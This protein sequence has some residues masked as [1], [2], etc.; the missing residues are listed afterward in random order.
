MMLLLNI[1]LKYVLDLI[2]MSS[3]KQ[4]Q[5]QQYNS[6]VANLGLFFTLDNSD[7]DLLASSLKICCIQVWYKCATFQTTTI[8]LIDI[9]DN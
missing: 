8:L 9:I 7:T 4:L 2:N 6:Y 5:Q 1:R 3:W